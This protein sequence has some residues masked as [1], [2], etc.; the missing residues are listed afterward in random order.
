MAILVEKHRVPFSVI[1]CIVFF[2]HFH[3]VPLCV[4]VV[5]ITLHCGVKNFVSVNPK[6]QGFSSQ[7]F[8]SA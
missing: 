1:M 5:A 6:Q 2:L 8:D 7:I 3:L 4:F